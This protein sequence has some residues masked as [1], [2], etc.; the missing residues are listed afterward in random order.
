M[1]ILHWLGFSQT[2]IEF[3]G[4]QRHSGESSY[5]ARRL[6]RLAVDGLFFQTTTLLRW[7]VYSGFTIAL[8]GLLLAL[9]YLAVYF[10]SARIP[11]GYTSIAVLLLLLIGFVIVSLGVVALYVGRIFEQG[12]GRPLF[13]ID[14]YAGPEQEELELERAE[15]VS[16]DR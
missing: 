1:L 16:S 11:A 2:S 3:E 7:V 13:I 5:N 8:V 10:T 4:D 15:A 9:Y 6:V 14:C 12:K